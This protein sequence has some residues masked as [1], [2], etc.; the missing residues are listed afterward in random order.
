MKYWTTTV[1]E[2]RSPTTN[3]KTGRAWNLLIEARDAMDSAAVTLAL[4]EVMTK[5]CAHTSQRCLRSSDA[6]LA[7][8]R[9][10]CYTQT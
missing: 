1:S 7:L 9:R 4:G 3:E 6:F 10:F 8:S 5:L 2:Q